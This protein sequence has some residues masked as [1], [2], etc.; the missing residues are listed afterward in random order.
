MSND[1]AEE[2]IMALRHTIAWMDLVMA[3]VNESILVL[4][5]NWRIIFANSYM[6]EI[7]GS[8][9]VQ[10]LGRAFWDVLP[11]IKAESHTPQIDELPVKLIASLNAVY[12]LKYKSITRKLQLQGKYVD[13]INQ[14]VCILSDVTVE[15]KAENALMALQKEVSNLKH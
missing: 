13:S 5:T 15:L 2:K 9:R 1:A 6:A 10:L 4:D 3:N 8:D 7:L 11:M 12:D 14:A